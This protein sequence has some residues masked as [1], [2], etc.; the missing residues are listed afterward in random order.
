MGWMMPECTGNGQVGVQRPALPLPRL[1]QLLDRAMHPELPGL[2]RG[3][4]WVQALRRAGLCLQALAPAH[5]AQPEVF[6]H[7]CYS[8]H[9]D[10]DLWGSFSKTPASPRCPPL[11]PA[12][13]RNEDW[14]EWNWG[15]RKANMGH[16]RASHSCGQLGLHPAG[17]WEELCRMH[18]ESVPY[19][20]SLP[21]GS[22]HLGQKASTKL[23]CKARAISMHLHRGSCLARAGIQR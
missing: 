9:T 3:A 6:R 11:S 19:W 7:A 21:I 17:A 8:S 13:D 5:W 14:Y 12:K 22:H 23:G 2:I 15:G 10:H 18:S 20:G 4:V 1:L 16:Y